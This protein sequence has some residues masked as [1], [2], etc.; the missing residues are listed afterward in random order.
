[1]V[2]TFQGYVE[3][4]AGATIGVGVSAISSTPRMIWQN[5][6]KLPVWEAAIATPRLPVERGFVLDE[7]DRVRAALIDRLMCDGAVDLGR[8]GR[9]HGVEPEAYFAAELA[10]LERL[11]ELARYDRERRAIETTA[12]GRLLVRNV[13]MVFDRYHR[14]AGGEPRFSSTI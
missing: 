5:H 8:L 14:P 12:M 2:R 1:M 13:C 11:R 3:Q 9:E 7:D 6:G 10:E 4:R